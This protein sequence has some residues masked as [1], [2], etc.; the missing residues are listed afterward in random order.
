MTT[1]L[2]ALP[3]RD[4]VLVETCSASASSAKCK[5]GRQV[6]IPVRR[7]APADP[8]PEA[9]HPRRS[10]CIWTDVGSAQARQ[11]VRAHISGADRQAERS[12]I[13][14]VEPLYVGLKEHS[15]R[16]RYGSASPPQLGSS[17]SVP[18]LSRSTPSANA[19]N[20]L[21]PRPRIRSGDLA[22]EAT[23]RLHD[24][25]QAFTQSSGQG[26]VAPPPKKI[27]RTGAPRGARRRPDE[28]HGTMRPCRLN[29]LRARHRC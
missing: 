14:V 10:G 15:P 19:Q 13:D 16:R 17:N 24:R 20:A 25:L 22:P 1:S 2:P 5:I 18:M 26:T 4:L 11:A 28:S 29:G 8:S 7:Q 12:Q 27:V 9:C 21:D 3:I 23:R 6:I